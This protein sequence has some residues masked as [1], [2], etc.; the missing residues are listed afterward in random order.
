[1]RR[2]FL[3]CLASLTAACASTRGDGVAF[4]P[5]VLATLGEK[6]GGCAVGDLLPQPGNEVAVV[7]ASGRMYVVGQ[8][9]VQEAGAAG[10]E[11]IQVAVGDL[12]PDRPGAELVAVGMLE[13][14][15]ES[16]GP[17]S[18]WVSGWQP[19]REQF[20]ARQVHV[21]SAL[22]HAVAV[23]DLDPT[24]P[25]DEA[26]VGGFSNSLTLL[27]FMPDGAVLATEVGSTPAAAK[28]MVP[29]RD[30]VA[31]ACRDGSLLVARPDGSGFDVERVFSAPA[32]L[33]RLATDG[34]R[35]LAASDDGSLWL[36]RGTEAVYMPLDQKK[37]RG[38]V[39]ADL[40]PSSPGLEAATAGYS[41]RIAMVRQP[42]SSR[43]RQQLFAGPDAWHHL[44]LGE[45]DPAPGPELVAVGFAGEVLM[46]RRG[47]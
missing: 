39:L 37:L 42:E 29:F 21:D 35:I 27:R 13:G 32:G 10:G 25:G 15:E 2:P 19:E 6:L 8:G 47:D 46:L 33:A 36:V 43:T 4:E 16:G 17:G 30:G 22:V 18:V 1:M 31:I 45:L 5:V 9:L 34:D 7:S 3:L 26:L 11:M 23:C 20:E 41:G 24:V 40:D 28:G 38:A 12:W 14:G 44:A